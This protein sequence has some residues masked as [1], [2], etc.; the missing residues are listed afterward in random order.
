MASAQLRPP[1]ITQRETKRKESDGGNKTFQDRNLC[2]DRSERFD[3]AS[4]VAFKIISNFLQSPPRPSAQITDTP[5][6]GTRPLEGW[7]A[8]APTWEGIPEARTP[9]SR[10]VEVECIAIYLI[11]QR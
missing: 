2:A 8:W 9:C 5:W 3:L 10:G 7:Q 4:A 1:E 6:G 11:G